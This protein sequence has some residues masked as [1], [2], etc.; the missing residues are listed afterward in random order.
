MGRA[1]SGKSAQKRGCKLLIN[2]QSCFANN[3]RILQD[4]GR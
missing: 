3:A 1:K 2:K 4:F